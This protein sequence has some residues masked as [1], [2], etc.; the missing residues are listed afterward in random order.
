MDKL[1]PGHM[2]NTRQN[3]RV[4]TLPA[5]LTVFEDIRRVL[6]RGHNNH[7]ILLDPGVFARHELYVLLANSAQMPCVPTRKDYVPHLVIQAVQR[8]IN[9]GLQL[10]IITAHGKGKPRLRQNTLPQNTQA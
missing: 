6:L 3:I 1:Q 5:L 9:Q 2:G 10:R 8:A 4:Q 7:R